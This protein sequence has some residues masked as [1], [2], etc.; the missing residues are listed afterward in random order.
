MK[1]SQELVFTIKE[2]NTQEFATKRKNTITNRELRK[3]E[4]ALTRLV[5]RQIEKQGHV[6][7][8]L[9]VRT[10]QVKVK[11]GARGNMITEVFAVDYW[12]YVNGDFDIY[13]NTK[14]SRAYKEVQKD[15][16]QLNNK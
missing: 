10:I 15:F 5:K 7:T 4:R 14:R 16:N 9:M 3:I 11:S 2:R 13:N 6:D 12:K 8:G 1:D